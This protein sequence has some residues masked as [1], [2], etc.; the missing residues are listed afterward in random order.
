MYF[1]DFINNGLNAHR[2]FLVF[3]TN[4]PDAFD[5][6]GMPR[7]DFKLN[8]NAGLIEDFPKEGWYECQIR[9]FKGTSLQK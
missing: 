6:N 2:R 1:E 7:T 8:S 4:N 3:Y 9:R 5:I